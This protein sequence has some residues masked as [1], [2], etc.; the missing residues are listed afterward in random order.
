MRLVKQSEAEKFANSDK[1][2]GQNYLLDESAMNLAVIKVTG[3]YP[4]ENL[5]ANEISKE[6]CYVL[7][8]GAKL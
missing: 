5:V 8:G 3:R 1:C 2:F 4:E 7:S 6:M